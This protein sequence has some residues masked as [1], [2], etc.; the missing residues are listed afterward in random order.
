MRVSPFHSP[1][2][3]VS[4]V[5]GPGQYFSRVK[6]AG[7]CDPIDGPTNNIF[8]LPLEF[9]QLGFNLVGLQPSEWRMGDTVRTDPMALIREQARLFAGQIARPTQ[10]SSNDEEDTRKSEKVQ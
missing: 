9:A 6:P 2:H 1:E 10:A 5:Q 3:A 7:R 4:F 8:K